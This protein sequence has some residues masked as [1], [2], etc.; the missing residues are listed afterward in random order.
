M[1][2]L[3]QKETPV[4][5]VPEMLIA[6]ADLYRDRNASYGDNYKRFGKVMHSLFPD[7]KKITGPDEWN[8]IGV[9]IQMV[10]KISRFVDGGM[11]HDDSLEDLSVYSTMLRELI[12]EEDAQKGEEP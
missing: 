10:S 11:H 12:S 6:S 9:F 2:D 3:T 4:K 7:G 5:T 1:D 8:Q